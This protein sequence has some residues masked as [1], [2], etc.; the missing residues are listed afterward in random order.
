MSKYV[1][2][3]NGIYSQWYPTKM[4]IDG[5]EFNCCEQWM[6][7]NKAMTFK[8]YGTAQDIMDAESPSQQ[9]ALGREVEGFDKKFGA[10]FVCQLFI[11]EI[12][13][14]FLKMKN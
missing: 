1:F 2:F 14:N 9:K 13:P 10:L 5:K 4:I 8:D 6:M 11:E 12:L 7:Y 3:W